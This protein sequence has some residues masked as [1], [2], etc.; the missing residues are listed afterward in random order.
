MCVPGDHNPAVSL[1]TSPTEPS[2]FPMSFLFGINFVEIVMIFL[3][4][5]FKKCIY[6]FV[7]MCV[8]RGQRR[9][10][11]RSPGTGATNGWKRCVG[12]GAGNQT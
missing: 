9:I 8:H 3:S 12:A 2:H 7:C 5:F 10:L 1:M 4:F 11:D 6:L